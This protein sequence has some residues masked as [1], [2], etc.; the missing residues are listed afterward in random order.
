MLPCE[1]PPW[2]TVCHWFRA[3]KIDGTFERRN[4]AACQRLRVHC[5]RDPQPSA[6]PIDN[7]SAKNTGV[8][9]EARGYSGGRKVRGRKRHILLDTEG[10]VVTAKV[11]G[12][13]VPDQDGVRLLESARAEAPRL[14]HLWVGADHRGRRSQ[15]N[16]KCA[17]SAVNSATSVRGL[18]PASSSCG[19]ALVVV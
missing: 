3:W 19:E 9:D 12:A 15:K 13:K 14:S 11:H 4:P 7:Q 10:L 6:G 17:S 8:G 2:K 18:S 5:G 16:Q 1:F